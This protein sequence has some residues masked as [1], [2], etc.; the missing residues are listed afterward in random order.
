MIV[1][2][3]TTTSWKCDGTELGWLT[4]AEEMIGYDCRFFAALEQDARGDAPFANLLDRLGENEHW[5]YRYD[6]NA[7]EINAS[8]RIARICAGRNMVTEYA[9]REGAEWVLFLDTD[10]TPD[11][12]CIPKLL[13]VDWPIVGGDVPSYCLGGPDLTHHPA[14]VWLEGGMVWPRAHRASFQNPPEFGYP[15]QQHWTTAGFLLVH[16]QLFRKLRW[17]CDPDAGMTDDPCYAA[18]A[19]A[20]GWPTLVRKDVIG[21]HAPCEPVGARGQDMTIFR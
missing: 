8:N 2:G 6:D 20:M 3:A 19:W 18:D 16:R 15:V 17:R 1:V 11:A 21:R 9:V 13:E 5:T 12:D 4:H 10:L 14:K 7:T